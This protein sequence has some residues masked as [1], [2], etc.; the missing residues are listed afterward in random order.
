MLPV[1]Q[2]PDQPSSSCSAHTGPS[3][4]NTSPYSESHSYST[5]GLKYYFLGETLT[6][7]PFEVI[8]PSSL[9]HPTFQLAIEGT[10]FNIQSYNFYY[11]YLLTVHIHYEAP[12]CSFSVASVFQAEN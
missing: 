9:S 11:D 2:A 10:Y 4:Q 7:F 12:L 8:A 3:A 1:L 6:D 5:P